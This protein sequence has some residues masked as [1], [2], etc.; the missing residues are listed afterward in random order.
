MLSHTTHSRVGPSFHSAVSLAVD[1][2]PLARRQS[3]ALPFDPERNHLYVYDELQA[4]ECSSS[5]AS[6]SKNWAA[7][8][9]RL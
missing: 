7:V 2:D 3:A 6:E 1:I 4:V 5:L 9:T 8:E